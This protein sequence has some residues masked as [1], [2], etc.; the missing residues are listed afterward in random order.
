VASEAAVTSDLPVVVVLPGVMGSHLWVERRD[1]V[2][3]DPLDIA[4]GGLARI[5][6]EQPGVEAE[7]LFEHVLRRPLQVPRDQPPC[8]ALRLRLAAAARC[9][10]PNA[11]AE[12]LD[13]LLRETQQPIRLLAHSMGGLVVR[14]CIHQAAAGDGCAD[15]ALRRSPGDARHAQPGRL[16]DGR[17][18]ARQG[19][20]AAF[21][22]APRRPA[23]HAG[24]ARDRF[25]FPGRVAVAAQARFRRH[26]SGSA[27]R[28]TGSAGFREQP[29]PGDYQKKVFDFWFGNG[30]S[31]TPSQEQLDAGSW[32]WQQDGQR[33]PRPCLK[34]YEPKSIYVFGVARN[35]PCG[36]REENGPPEDGR[37]DAAVTA[38]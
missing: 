17:E 9:R 14:A 15:G 10:L 28:W 32:L 24:S 37:H 27:G 21:A 31:A 18:P 7:K 33:R 11:L 34:A 20:Y 38:R 22:G 25:R 16:L 30:K 5:A 23:R 13:R 12:L 35:T 26:L 6:W 1:R 36:I 29:R 2:W 8:R 3:F 4:R 19:R